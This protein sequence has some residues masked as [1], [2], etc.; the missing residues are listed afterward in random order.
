MTDTFNADAL[1]AALQEAMNME[2]V[3]IGLTMRELC[4]KTGKGERAIRTAL[5]KIAN[6]GKLGVRRKRIVCIDGTHGTPSS[7]YLKP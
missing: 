5:H 2:D 1:L 3:G 7:Y 4:E 6:S